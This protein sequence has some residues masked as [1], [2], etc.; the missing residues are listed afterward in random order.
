MDRRSFVHEA[1]LSLEPGVDRGAPGAAITMALCGHWE[2]TPP[3]RWPHNSQLV[4]VSGASW[5][6][7][8]F[9][10]TGEDEPAIRL[11]IEAALSSSSDWSVLDSGPGTLSV[12]DSALAARLL[13]GPHL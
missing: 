6:R 9:V 7:T 2:H 8:I 1:T 4:N 13:A 3:C 10:S 11:E 5:L 12:A